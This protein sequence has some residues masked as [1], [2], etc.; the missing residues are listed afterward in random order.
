HNHTFDPRE[1]LRLLQHTL[2]PHECLRLD[3]WRAGYS[4]EVGYASLVGAGLP[5]DE[6]GADD[7]DR[8]TKR[9]ACKAPIC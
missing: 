9:M 3:R 7:I 2:E 1:C 8:Q 5:R 4:S 6:G